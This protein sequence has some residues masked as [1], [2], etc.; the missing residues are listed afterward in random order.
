MFLHAE[1]F[2]DIASD[3]FED[4]VPVE[5]SVVVDADCGLLLGEKLS[6]DPNL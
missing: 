6:V 5:E 1:D 3:A 4:T 2:S